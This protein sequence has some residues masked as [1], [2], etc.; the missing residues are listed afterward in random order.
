MSSGRGDAG[1]RSRHSIADGDQV[2]LQW[3]SRVFAGSSPIPA[4]AE[5]L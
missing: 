2:A 4:D 3:T 5:K 1:E